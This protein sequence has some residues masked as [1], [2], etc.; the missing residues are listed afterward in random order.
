M[1]AEGIPSHLHDKIMIYLSNPSF[2]MFHNGS[3]ESVEL[4]DSQLPTPTPWKNH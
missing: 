3:R 4:S 1:E 2:L